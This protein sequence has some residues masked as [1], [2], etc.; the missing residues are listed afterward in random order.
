MIPNNVL[1]EN[2]SPSIWRNLGT[3]TQCFYKEYITIWILIKD[4][5]PFCATL[6]G[7]AVEV[8][9]QVDINSLFYKYPQVECIILAEE[10][11]LLRYYLDINKKIESPISA[12]RYFSYMVNRLTSD[13]GI[14]YY[15]R[16]DEVLPPPPWV[17]FY[18]ICRQMIK[19]LLP[20]TCC[21]L[22]EIMEHG[23]LFFQIV[24]TIRDYQINRISTIDDYCNLLG[25]KTVEEPLSE[26]Q[27]EQI[28]A[29]TPERVIYN[30]VEKEFALNFLED[31]IKTYIK[32]KVYI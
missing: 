1:A 25:L 5:I 21:L 27:L 22:M 18:G 3:F 11:S 29:E 19:E 30:R 24:L 12:D 28:K 20:Q 10:E 4:G 23:K 7:E 17:D 9:N 6:E 32:A 16:D 14:S 26:L 2:L 13:K 15:L 31:K 8:P